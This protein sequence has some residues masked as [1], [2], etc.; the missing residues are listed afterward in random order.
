M[1]VAEAYSVEIIKLILS[2]TIT[3]SILSVFLFIAKP[4]IKDKLPKSLD[5]KSVV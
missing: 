2:M 1:T 3:G 5:R 4:F